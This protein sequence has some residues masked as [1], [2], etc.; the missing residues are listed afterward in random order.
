[1]S[2]GQT[3]QYIFAYKH[4]GQYFAENLVGSLEDELANLEY[5]DVRSGQYQVWEYPSGKI[6]DIAP[7][8]ILDEGDNEYSL[9]NGA[10]GVVWR[11]LLNEVATDTDKIEAAYS[12]LAQ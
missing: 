10:S 7:D 5:E 2:D 9:P 11:P 4:D 1:M 12:K 8:R 6:Y 3:T